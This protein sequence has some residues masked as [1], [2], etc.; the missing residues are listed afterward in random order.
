MVGKPVTYFSLTVLQK[1]YM[2]QQG[3]RRSLL[4]LGFE[5]SSSNMSL[6][7]IPKMI[8]TSFKIKVVRS[9]YAKPHVTFSK[10]YSSSNFILQALKL[11]IK[12][13]S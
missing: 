12:T 8:D 1:S 6:Y 11:V 7:M 13:V 3:Y 10:R 2:V 5:D 9:I 4:L